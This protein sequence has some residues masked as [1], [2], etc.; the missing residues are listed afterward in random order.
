MPCGLLRVLCHA[1][2]RNLQA[3]A[4]ADPESSGAAVAATAAAAAAEDQAA[5]S[6]YVATA[7]ASTAASTAAAAELHVGC[8]VTVNG[9]QVCV[10]V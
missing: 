5:A 4:K 3:L 8:S 9:L 1:F 10:C 6:S 7:A 2:I